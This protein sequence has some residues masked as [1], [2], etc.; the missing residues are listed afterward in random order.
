MISSLR[1][2]F[3]QI[4]LLSNTEDRK[5][6]PLKVGASNYRKYRFVVASFIRYLLF[7]FY[8]LDYTIILL[9]Q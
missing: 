4:I 7:Q 1:D 2:L 5:V 8:V 3:V 6:W 9:S